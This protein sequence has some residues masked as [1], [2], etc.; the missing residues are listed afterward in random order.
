M[1]HYTEVHETDGCAICE[2]DRKK[3]GNTSLSEALQK[4]SQLASRLAALE[5]LFEELEGYAYSVSLSELLSALS[6]L[7]EGDHAAIA[8]LVEHFMVVAMNTFTGDD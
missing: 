1:N 6:L 7:R 2:T 4:V 8:G 3:T 5:S